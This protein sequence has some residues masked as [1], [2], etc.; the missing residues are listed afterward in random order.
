MK[1]GKRKHWT[2]R[3]L[4]MK[5]GHGTVVE[6]DKLMKKKDRERLRKSKGKETRLK[7]RR[8]R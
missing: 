7:E 8:E 3:E 2:E 5:R 6:R 4:Q 1:R